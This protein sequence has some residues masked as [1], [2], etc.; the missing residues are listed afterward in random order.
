[1]LLIIY[2]MITLCCCLY[3]FC[4]GGPAGRL[5]AG[6]VAF[7][8]IAA[9]YAALMDQSW[10]HTVYA[11]LG[12]DMIC[13]T[14]FYMLA[15]SSDS[16]WPLWATGCALAAVTVHLAS[17]AQFGIDPKVYHGLKGLWGIPMQL[18]MVRGIALDIRY[19]RS[20]ANIAA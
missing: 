14:A 7:K 4:A 17:I 10:G 2:W 12:V 6:L 11:V 13:L 3:A 9:F 5:G 18:F 19:Q 15:V 20:L 16:Y 1:M 8:T